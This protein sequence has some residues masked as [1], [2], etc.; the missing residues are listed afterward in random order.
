MVDRSVNVL[1]RAVGR[2]SRRGV[3]LPVIRRAGDASVV[4][5]TYDD[6]PSERTTPMLLEVL[7][8]FEAKA[9]FFLT[10][11]RVA[12]AP[13]LVRQICADGHA[14]Y[15]HGWEHVRYDRETPERLLG[16]LERTETELRRVRPT[17]QPYLVRLPYAAGLAETWVHES[18]RRWDP[19]V[20]F[21]HW[22]D[23]FLDWTLADGC[24]TEED[25]KA[26]CGRAIR[27]TLRRTNPAGAVFLLHEDPFDVTAALSPVVVPMLT[28]MLLEQVRSARLRAE[29]VS[30]AKQL[31]R[32]RAYIRG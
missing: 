7:R 3:W 23:S 11:V 25:L 31:P 4:G 2:F 26:A 32:Y 12:A 29:V 21:A 6:G 1:R 16:D 20:H 15:A 28:R 18:L 8:A 19:Q 14:I 30:A 24:E 9:T 22:A 27:Q 5:L 13:E 17:P 10:G